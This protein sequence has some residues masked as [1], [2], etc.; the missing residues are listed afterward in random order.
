MWDFVVHSFHDGL[1][2]IF[3]SKSE[4]KEAVKHDTLVMCT[5][6]AVNYTVCDGWRSRGTDTVRLTLKPI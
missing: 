4:K 2:A 5:A 6:C 1:Q 3:R